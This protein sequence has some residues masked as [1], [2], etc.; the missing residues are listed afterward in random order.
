MMDKTLRKEKLLAKIQELL[1]TD[2]NL[3]FL[4]GWEDKELESLFASL[5]D[6]LSKKDISVGKFN[7]KMP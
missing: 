6:R 3:D 7:W 2:L 4:L 5:Q 1:T